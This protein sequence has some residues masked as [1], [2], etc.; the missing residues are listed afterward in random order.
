MKKITYLFII[1]LLLTGC[2][3]P[4]EEGPKNTDLCILFTNDVHCKYENGIGYAGV[5]SLKKECSASYPNCLLVD[6]GDFTQGGAVAS[7]SEGKASIDIIN[8]VALDNIISN[9]P[10]EK[11]DLSK[12]GIKDEYIDAIL[13][14]VN[15]YR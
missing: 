7:I 2:E 10:S 13:K 12:L 15:L 6:S 14:I 3:K 5:A 11:E 1:S 4:I 9:F 8:E